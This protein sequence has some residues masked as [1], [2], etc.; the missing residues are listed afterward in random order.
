MSNIPDWVQAAVASIAIVG[1]ATGTYAAL[2]SDINLLSSNVN[3]VREEIRKGEDYDA[4]LTGDLSSMN[5]RIIKNEANL[6][7]LAKGQAELALSVK[8]LTKQITLMNE[9]LVKIII[10]QEV[11]DT[12]KAKD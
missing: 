8:E 10:K 9:N 2:K 5:D 3:D 7:F 1:G 4:I 6:D 12:K 11:A